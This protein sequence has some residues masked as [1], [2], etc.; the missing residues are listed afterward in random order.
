MKIKTPSSVVV[1]R[2]RDRFH[3]QIGW[4]DSWHSFSFGSHYDPTNTGHGL[5]LVSNDDIIRPR[6]GFM[7]HPHRDMEIVTWV[8]EGELEH[9]DSEGN[10]GVITP[11]LAQRMSAGT[12]I[13]HSEMNPSSTKEVRLVQMWVPPD[14]ERVKPSYEQLDISQDLA[15]GGLVPV[16]SGRRGGAIRIQQKD[17]TLWA[18]RLAPA[19]KVNIPPSSHAHVFL[20]KGEAT[21]EG[22]GLLSGGDAARLISAGEL[23]ITAGPHGAEVLIWE[24]HAQS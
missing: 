21:L 6:S 3:T 14:N 20:A 24:T 16:A 2:A 9:R 19:A 22:S 10:R 11:G 1:R 4:L 13:W 18:A 15:R 7:T 17:A 5:L 8:L 12:G 23:A